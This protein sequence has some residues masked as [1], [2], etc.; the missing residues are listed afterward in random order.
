MNIVIDLYYWPTPNGHKISIMLEECGLP[1]EV[2]RVDIGAG[3]QFDPE[4][5]AISP[6]N[7]MPAI[8]DRDTGIAVFESGAILQYLAEKTQRFLPADTAGRYDVRWDGRDSAGQRVAA[9][10]YFYRLV[11]DGQTLTKKMTVMK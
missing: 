6:N 9:G 4:F 8:A 2:H 1:Y 10:V 3:D 11:A 7:R 5:L